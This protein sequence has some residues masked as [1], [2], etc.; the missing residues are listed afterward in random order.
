MNSENNQ[1]IQQLKQELKEREPT[2]TFLKENKLSSEQFEDAFFRLLQNQ[3]NYDAC[4]NC[5]GLEMCASDVYGYSSKVVFEEGRVLLK[6]FACKYNQINTKELFDTF[7]FPNFEMFEKQNELF[8]TNE[9]S[10]ILKK[11]MQFLTT[12]KKEG[13]AKGIYLH[14]SFGTGKTFIMYHLAKK[15][16]ELDKKVLFAYYPDLVQQIKNSISD[17]KLDQHLM[18]IKKVDVLILDDIGGESNSPFV[19]DDILGP[20]LQYRMTA[21]LPTFMTSNYST[22][23]LR[24]HLAETKDE[25][26]KVRT[27]R[28]IERLRFMMEEVEL[29]G[30]NYRK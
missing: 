10:I 1:I 30:E 22:D 18:R 20:I 7:Y 26:N 29:R 19:R 14:G 17:G 12:Y 25:I 28:I 13:Y 8:K 23:M 9:R 2:K 3:Q 27:D 21:N 16:V 11:I 24:T 15:I 4:K 5:R 6:Y